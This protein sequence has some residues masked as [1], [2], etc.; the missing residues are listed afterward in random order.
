MDWRLGGDSA[1]STAAMAAF[2]QARSVV[3][4]AGTAEPV[5]AFT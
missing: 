2:A 3:S 5:P 1:D 4:R